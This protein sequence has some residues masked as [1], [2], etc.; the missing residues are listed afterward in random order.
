MSSPATAPASIGFAPG[1]RLLLGHALALRYHPLE[2]LDA[3]RGQGDIVVFWIGPSRAYLINSPDLVRQVLTTH[4]EDF[5]KGGPLADSIRVLTGNGLPTADEDLHRRQRRLMQPAFHPSR[6][7]GYVTIMQEAAAAKLATWSDQQVLAVDQETHDLITTVLGRCLCSGRLSDGVLAEIA[8]L[9]PVAFE[10]IGRRAALPFRWLHT[11]PTRK[12]RRF[13]NAFA[14]LHT[15]ADQLITDR[16]ANP[17]SQD[18]ADILSVLLTTRDEQ[19]G[20]PMPDQQIHDEIMAL[21]VAGSDTA[22]VATSWALHLIGAH[23]DIEDQVHAELRQVLDGRPITYADFP[24]LGYLHR[25]ITEAIRLRPPAWLVPRRATTD[26]DLGGHRIARGSTV[27]FSPYANHHDPIL[28]PDPERF[29]PDRWLSEQAQHLPR[30]AYLPF[31]AGTRQC[32]GDTFALAEITVALATITTQWR[33]RPHPDHPV[34]PQA[35][36]TLNPGQLRM[37]AERRT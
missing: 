24:R 30:C 26:V 29:D 1:R 11:V 17:A 2:F 35:F 5:P 33:L 28:F 22:A 12:N 34:R 19:T 15:I 32:I 7:P 13:R 9:M 8:R 25:V 36:T 37:I 18:D 31:G 6:F 16:K 14:R 10:G 27:F 23:P 20:Q 3:Q 4:R 21:I